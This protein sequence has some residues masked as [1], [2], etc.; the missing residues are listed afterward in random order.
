M[1]I[2][3]FLSM[4]LLSFD[5]LS[6]TYEGKIE[7]L[8]GKS[9]D[10]S[11]PVIVEEGKVA[12]SIR[13]YVD[14]FAGH[15]AIYAYTKVKNNSAADQKYAFHASFYDSKGDLIAV[16]RHTVNLKQGVETQ[17]GGM[18]SEVAPLEWKKV[19]SY[20]VKVTKL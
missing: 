14:D 2:P 11:A 9:Y 10:R 16:C 7:L 15:N 4:L 1:R 8:E 12:Y 5:V 20:K 19:A 6:N 3:L 18:Y 17:L 13:F